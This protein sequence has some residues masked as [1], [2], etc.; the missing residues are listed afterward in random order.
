MVML[1]MFSVGDTHISLDP[2]RE[3]S[4][5]KIAYVTNIISSVPSTT[6]STASIYFDVIYSFQNKKET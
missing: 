3:K 2:R 6:R 4:G 5:M 1:M